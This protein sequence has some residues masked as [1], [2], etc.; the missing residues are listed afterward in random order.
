MSPAHSW[1]QSGLRGGR[2]KRAPLHHRPISSAESSRPTP[3]ARQAP[4][5]PGQARDGGSAHPELSSRAG[6]ALPPQATGA[7]T[8]STGPAQSPQGH[9]LEIF[10]CSPLRAPQASEGH[11]DVWHSV[12]GSARPH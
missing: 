3:Q 11:K 10:S 8:Q 7:R 5:P 1:Y 12:P 9:G 2:R 6:A 4:R